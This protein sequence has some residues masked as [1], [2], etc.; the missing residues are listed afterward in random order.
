MLGELRKKKLAR[1]IWTILAIII[2]PA[3]I[4]WGSSSIIR[5]KKES[6]YV[7]KIFGKNISTLEF[8]DAI[9]AVKN[10]AILDYG[11]DALSELEKRN[12]ESEAWLRLILL[13]E[14]KRQKINV[15]DNEVARS[16]QNLPIFQKKG[17]FDNSI[18]Q[19]L[20]KYTFNTQPR[21]FEEQ[22]RQDLKIFKLYSQVTSSI[23]VD[24]AEVEKEYRKLN[25]ELSIDYLAA[26][27]ADFEKDL[28]PSEEEIKNYFSENPLE[29]QQPP[30]F[31]LE[32]I[33]LEAQGAEKTIVEEKIKE[34]FSRLN[35]AEEFSEVAK[36]YDLKIKETG[37]FAQTEAIPEIGWV[38]DVIN[39]AAQAPKGQILPPFLVENSY[40]ICKIKEKKQPYIPELETI[41]DKVKQALIKNKAAI[42]AKEELDKCLADLTQK[43]EPKTKKINFKRLAGH[44]NLKSG[45]TELFKFGSEIEGIGASDEFFLRAQELQE[46]E[47]SE[48]IQA[49]LGYYIIRIKEKIEIDKN[50]FEKE[51]EEFREKLL[52]QKKMAYFQN[53]IEELKTGRR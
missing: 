12:L 7:G 35:L 11:E 25:E 13:A 30:S 16:I 32:Y 27:F 14:A 22:I 10:R 5:G 44:Y 28:N 42:L 38:P 24:A 9:N 48:I 6:A 52:M 51:K 3:F 29:F 26:L 49:A 20:L 1:M 43:R 2:V 45:T 23:E 40:Y 21:S 50:K 17:Q 15:S 37:L 4:F 53:Y 46:N 19:Y 36:D 31:N 39:L 8:Q 33:S 34:I 18:Y 47:L 41:K